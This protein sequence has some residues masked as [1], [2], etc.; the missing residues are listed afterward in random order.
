MNKKKINIWITGI[1][2][3]LVVLAAVL[4]FVLSFN[5]LSSEAAEHGVNQNLSSLIPIILDGLVVYFGMYIVWAGM[6]NR[7][8]LRWLGRAVVVVATILS[9]TL[10]WQ[11][12]TGSWLSVVYFI[13][14]PIVLAVSLL[15]LEFMIEH[16][17]NE[18]VTEH[19]WQ[20][21]F[22]ELHKRYSQLKTD[23]NGNQSLIEQLQTENGRL[24]EYNLLMQSL[25][26]EWLLI[27]KAHAGVIEKQTV[28]DT[29][30]LDKRTVTNRFKMLEV[31][32]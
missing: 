10:N 11:H 6:N 13:T 15:S 5:V 2:F 22:E 7:D 19:T 24:H 27:I 18:A 14:P 16:A 28:Y 12:S 17:I 30:P 8:G 25:P 1:T 3:L 20:A 4:S 32:G 31:E 9:V 26:N 29:L 21:K 23:A